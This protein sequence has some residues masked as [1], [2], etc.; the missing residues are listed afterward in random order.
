M[1]KGECI[2]IVATKA[3]PTRNF[4]RVRF[5]N[6]KRFRDGEYTTPKW[7]TRAAQTIG[8]KYYGVSGCKITMAKPKEGSWM[9]QSVL[10]PKGEKVDEKMALKIANHIQD[11][12]EKEGQWA[13]KMCRDNETQRFVGANKRKQHIIRDS[14]GRFAPHAAEGDYTQ[15]RSRAINNIL[16]ELRDLNAEQMFYTLLN[17]LPTKQANQLLNQLAKGLAEGEIPNRNLR[18]GAE[19]DDYAE[20]KEEIL[21]RLKGELRDLR[22]QEMRL[23]DV[24]DDSNVPQMWNYTQHEERSIEPF[25]QE[26]LRRMHRF[27]D[28][29]NRRLINMRRHIRDLSD[30]HYWIDEFYGTRE[31]GAETFEAKG[32]DTFAD[33]F[34]EL[35]GN[36]LRKTAMTVGSVVI[37]FLLGKRY[38]GD[39]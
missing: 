21:R 39:V 34:N 29:E 25:S 36:G 2:D 1:P 13:K 4:Y 23:I 33:P 8:T 14:R 31:N 26:K 32:I 17:Y 38:G 24:W 15:P 7:A 9:I 6:P 19:E 18:L 5:R 16:W 11:R 10:I 20:G 12:I 3:D 28:N 35:K 27:Y 37:G 22:R 30:Y